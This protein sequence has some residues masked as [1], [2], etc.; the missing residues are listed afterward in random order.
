MRGKVSYCHGWPLTGEE[1]ELSQ[2][3]QGREGVFPYVTFAWL[4]G[5][6][7]GMVGRSSLLV[8]LLCSGH[9]TKYCTGTPSVHGIGILVR[10]ALITRI[11]LPVYA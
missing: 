9:P 3:C 6:L 10:D 1:G 4:G 11:Q 8:L 5:S 7:T 2:A